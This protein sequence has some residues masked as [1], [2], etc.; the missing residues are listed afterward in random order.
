M[1]LLK[2]Y[3]SPRV[4]STIAQYLRNPKSYPEALQALRQR[5]GDLEMID[6]AHVAELMSIPAIRDNSQESLT[7]FSA[8]LR[9]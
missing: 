8:R 1:Q 2:S 3:L 4:R 7:V 6:R 9:D 5:Y